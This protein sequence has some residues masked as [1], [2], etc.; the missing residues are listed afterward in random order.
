M[1][2]RVF[3]ETCG[4]TAAAAFSPVLINAA[5]AQSRRN[6]FNQEYKADIVIVGAG[7][8]GIAAAMAACEMGARVILTETT[9]WIGG[10][11]SQQGVPPDEH[12]WIESI[13]GTSSYA[14]YRTL[15]RQYYRQH[16]PLTNSARDVQHLNPG[17]GAVSRIC[18]EP[19]VSLAVLQSMLASAISSGRLTLILNCS[20][21]S[22]TVQ[23]D[24]IESVRCLNANKNQYLEL[25][26]GIFIDATEEGDLLPISGTEYVLGAESQKQTGEP[27]APAQADPANIQALTYCFAI[28]HLEGEDYTIERPK[29]YDFW[30]SYVPPLDP[31]WSGPILSLSYSFPRTLAPKALPF[32]PC[33]RQAPAP[34]TTDLN[35]WLYRRMID[36]ANFKAGS[37]A[38]DISLINWPQNDYMLGN[39]TDVAPAEREK[40]LY[41]A[42]QQSLSLLYWLQTEAPRPDGKQGWPGLRLRK[43]IMGTEDGLAKYPYIRESRRIQAEFTIL[44]QHLTLEERKKVVTDTGSQMLAQPFEDT[45]G[46]GYY[47]LDLH[48]ST[49]GNNYIDTPSVPFQ[50]PLGAMI[51]IRMENLLPACKNI[52]T[53][54]ISNGCYRLHPVEWSIG[55]A[56]GRLAAHSLS[57]KLSPRQVRNKPQELAAFQELLAKHGV[58]LE[59]NL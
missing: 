43:D 41:Q 26:A 53:T 22:A 38:S 33:S 35:L 29:M 47:H 19:Q 13:A 36:R 7:L 10:Q 32:I 11:V 31:P 39:I 48:P 55:E 8:G 21:V 23:G 45:V 17:N 5:A 1:R 59:W 44:E 4:L 25:Q 52:G 3:L 18:H 57:Q 15:V 54:H 16:Y 27:H 28:D 6:Y 56:A 9:D 51:P 37:Y 50:I 42:K 46:I 58:D 12:Q 30:K 34:N 14:R 2:R 20:T 49:G 40:H 24:R